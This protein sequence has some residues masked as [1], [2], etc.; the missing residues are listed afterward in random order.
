MIKFNVPLR[1]LNYRWLV[2]GIPFLYIFNITGLWFDIHEFSYTLYADHLC[3]EVGETIYNTINGL[4][5]G[6][7]ISQKQSSH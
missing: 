5:D 7:G 6:E 3:F 1:E 2:F 4:I